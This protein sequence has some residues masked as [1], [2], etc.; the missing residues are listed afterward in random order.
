MCRPR[1]SS[2]AWINRQGSSRGRVSGFSGKRSQRTDPR[3]AE[4]NR[5]N[6]LG[7]GEANLGRAFRR[8]EGRWTQVRPS[9]RAK[10]REIKK[11]SFYLPALDDAHPPLQ[12]DSGALRAQKWGSGIFPYSPEGDYMMWRVRIPP[13]RVSVFFE[14]SFALKRFQRDRGVTGFGRSLRNR[15]HL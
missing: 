9:G 1:P 10:R 14:D 5:V 7:R 11:D 15:Y 2:G 13:A 6:G 4:Q 8:E 3:Q 12:I